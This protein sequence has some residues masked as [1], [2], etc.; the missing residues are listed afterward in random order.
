MLETFPEGVPIVGLLLLPLVIWLGWRCVGQPRL[1]WSGLALLGV[2]LLLA[3]PYLPVFWKFLL[4]QIQWAETTILRGAP[5]PFPGLLDARRLP[6]FFALGE[7]WTGA[8]FDAW[9]NVVPAVLLGLLALGTWSCRRTHGW[10]PWVAVPLA[11][12]LLWQNGWKKYDYGTYKV[13]FCAGWWIYPTLVAGV[14]GLV[15][16]VR[17]P[18]WSLGWLLVLLSAAIGWEKAAHRT[19]RGTLPTSDMGPLREL[20]DLRYVTQGQPLLLDFNGLNYLWSVYYLRHLPITSFSPA[21]KF[22]RSGPRALF[23]AVHRASPAGRAF[24]ARARKASGIHL[25]RQRLFPHPVPARL[26]RRSGGSLR[27]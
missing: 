15:R 20:T 1:C 17:L 14:A 16:M 5:G 11:A 24:R 12:L 2:G 26:H 8:A 22:G 19:Y 7:E 21:G 4:N 25:D 27:G 13:L 3:S 9:H 10:L 6:A 18:P 23:G